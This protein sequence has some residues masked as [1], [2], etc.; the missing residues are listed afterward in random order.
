MST[1]PDGAVTGVILARI[2]RAAPVSSSTVS[3]RTRS[4]IR[5]APIWAGVAAPAVAD[6]HAL[7]DRF[8]EGCAR[9]ESAD[10]A[11][12]L[13]SGHRPTLRRR[14]AGRAMRRRG[15]RPASSK[16]ASSA[17]PCSRGDALEVELHGVHRMR[18]VL[19][20][21]DDAVGGLAV[22]LQVWG[23]ARALDDQRVVARHLEPRRQS[24]E[25]AWPV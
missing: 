16:L 14:R 6:Q 1:A 3:P 24:P 15:L 20:A 22:D 8:I 7:H 23:Q 25:H 18:A 11:L 4:A 9:G 5:K 2:M 21:H 10:D 13:G 17:W 19:Q 12:D